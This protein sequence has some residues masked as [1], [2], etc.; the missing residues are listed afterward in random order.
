MQTEKIRN[1]RSTL[2]TIF[3]V[4]IGSSIYGQ[5]LVQENKTWNVVNCIAMGGC[6]TESFKINGDTIIDQIDYKKLLRTTDT[7]LTNWNFF[8][9]I[10][11]VDNR[12]FFRHSFLDS[13]NMLY[14]F[15]LSVG[16]TFSSFYY[17]CPIELKIQDIDTV[18][19]LN[20]EQRER[21]VLSN[22]EQW[23]KGIGSLNGLIYVGVY[24]C[25]A[26][27]Y[28]ELSCCFENGEQIFQ[29]DNYES[30]FVISVGINEKKN[31]L[32]HKV[33]PNPFSN[34]TILKFDYLD[35]QNYVLHIINQYG[36]I[37]HTINSITSGEIEI[38]KGRMNKGVY[39]Y[40][41]ENKKG[42]IASGKMILN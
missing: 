42:I 20:G 11:E 33:Y 36:Q 30:C 15:N 12:I 9:A 39:Y 31:H 16:D 41:L 1:M 35:S 34:S 18:T 13:E 10:R 25:M 26:D 27:M 22:S 6:W 28:Y 21:Y 29:S 38:N 40:R 14:D 24:W 23:I 5:T 3:I 37:I 32:K 8:G 2:I 19:I 17:D 7:T 4:I